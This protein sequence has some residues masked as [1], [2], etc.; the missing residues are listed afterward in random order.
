MCYKP[1]DNLI[2]RLQHNMLT[3]ERRAT[4]PVLICVYKYMCIYIYMQMEPCNVD[5][6]AY[7]GSGNWRV[8]RA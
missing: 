8:C 5:F 6:R 2:S 3:F 1:N 7:M 4:S